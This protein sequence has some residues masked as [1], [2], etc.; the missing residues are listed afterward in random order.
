MQE[1]GRGIADTEGEKR[2]R[3]GRFA[4]RIVFAQSESLDLLEKTSLIS[5]LP[6]GVGW[7]GEKIEF[8]RGTSGFWEFSAVK[9]K[10]SSR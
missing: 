9:R 5:V 1:G 6:S 7:G 8:W 3:K 4:Y 10:G 2:Q